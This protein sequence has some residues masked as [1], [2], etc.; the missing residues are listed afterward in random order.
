MMRVSAMAEFRGLYSDLVLLAPHVGDVFAVQ[1]PD[2]CAII[3]NVQEG[4]SVRLTIDVV[5][6]Y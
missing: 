5:R 1:F 3:K 2:E 4:G 6:K